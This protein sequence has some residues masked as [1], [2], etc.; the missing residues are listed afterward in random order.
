MQIDVQLDII[1]L[2]ELQFKFLV[3]LVAIVLQLV[4]QHQLVL[5]QLDIIVLLK[6]HLLFLMYVQEVIIAH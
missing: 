1:V 6:V 4:F 3:I 5:V 2:R